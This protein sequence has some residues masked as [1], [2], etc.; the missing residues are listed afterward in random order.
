MKLQPPQNGPCIGKTHMFFPA[1]PRTVEIIANEREAK[2][3]CNSCD[4]KEMCLE[5]SLHH[6]LYGIWGGVNESAREKLRRHRGIRVVTPVTVI[7]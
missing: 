4:Q 1:S 6:E 2:R 5:Y 3:L 7:S